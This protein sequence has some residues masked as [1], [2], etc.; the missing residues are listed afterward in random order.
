MKKFIVERRE[1]W[2]QDIEVEAENERDAID[3]VES[4]DFEPVNEGNFEYSHVMDSD[5]WTVKEA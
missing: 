5:T 1:V 4:N 2:V 3:L